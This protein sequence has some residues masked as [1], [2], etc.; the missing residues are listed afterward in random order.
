[1]QPYREP[2]LTFVSRSAGEEF[3]CDVCGLRGRRE[4][5]NQKRHG[6]E[7]RRKAMAKRDAKRLKGGCTG[8][9]RA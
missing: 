4:A 9:K 8:R 3:T 5:P 1:M 2:G 6:G 7:C